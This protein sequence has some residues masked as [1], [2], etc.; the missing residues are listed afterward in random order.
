MPIIKPLNIISKIYT[1]RI[2][3]SKIEVFHTK[4]IF[5]TINRKNGLVK[6]SR[7]KSAQNYDNWK[8]QT[9]TKILDGYGIWRNPFLQAVRE[10][11]SDFKLNDKEIAVVEESISEIKLSAALSGAVYRIKRGKEN[12]VL[13]HNLTNPDFIP[14]WKIKKSTKTL[15]FSQ[16]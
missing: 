8:T 11:N 4:E 16:V 14:E 9:L 15:D 7:P 6:I 3:D 13:V 2:T 1:H 12:A 5:L 10:V